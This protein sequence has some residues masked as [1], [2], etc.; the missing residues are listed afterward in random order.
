M[1]F[2]LCLPDLAFSQAK[3]DCNVDPSIPSTWTLESSQK[4]GIYVFNAA[5]AASK[6]KPF[7]NIKGWDFVKE[8]N[9]TGLNACV[10]D[11]LMKHKELIPEAW[12]E[13]KIIVFTGSV[14]KDG[15]GSLCLRH[16]SWW[17]NDWHAEATYPETTY[18]DGRAAATK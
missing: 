4:D 5:E 10:L 7:K 17:D 11:F 2:V 18:D 13:K 6:I 12:K 9:G 3:I 1:G 15:G 16:L 8:L 14:F